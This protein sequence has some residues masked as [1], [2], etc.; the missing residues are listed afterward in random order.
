M[1][2]MAD[3]APFADCAVALWKSPTPAETETAWRERPLLWPRARS[4]TRPNPV[5]AHATLLS[6]TVSPT[7]SIGAGGKGR[8]PMRSF[9]T[10]TVDGGWNEASARAAALTSIVTNA[11][12]DEGEGEH[13]AQP[14]VPHLF[15]LYGSPSRSMCRDGGV[16]SRDGP[17]DPYWDPTRDVECDS[18]LDG[19]CIHGAILVP[20]A[21]ATSGA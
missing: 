15:P 2:T 3:S 21:I 7:G 16:A 9:T 13:L 8:R 14:P 6:S 12:L 19:R 10:R 17:C 20:S 4:R 18:G 11:E 1:N 5:V